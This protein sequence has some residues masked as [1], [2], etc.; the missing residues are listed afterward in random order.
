MNLGI[1]RYISSIYEAMDLLNTCAQLTEIRYWLISSQLGENE[2]YI[3][4]ILLLDKE[5][6]QVV[7][8]LT[9]LSEMVDDLEVCI[10]QCLHL[11]QIEVRKDK[12][13][14]AKYEKYHARL[15]KNKKQVAA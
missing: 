5:K 6:K 9:R 12:K 7:R 15:T 2:N 14:A 13:F 8:H 3:G 11:I 10:N 4:A 1:Q